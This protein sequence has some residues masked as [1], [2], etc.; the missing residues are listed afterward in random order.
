MCRHRGRYSSSDRRH[1][2]LDGH[3]QSGDGGGVVIVIV[4]VL[5]ILVVVILVIVIEAAAV[6]QPLDAQVCLNKVCNSA[7][8]YNVQILYQLPFHSLIH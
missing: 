4:M 5:V 8:E 6:K 1:D 2:G 3:C 7:S